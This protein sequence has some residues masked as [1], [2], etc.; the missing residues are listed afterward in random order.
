M[1]NNFFVDYHWKYYLSLEN[2]FLFTE[3]YVSFNS[4]NNSTFS[5]EYVKLLQ[6]I[7][8]EI[9]S[10]SKTICLNLDNSFAVDKNTNI[11]KWGFVLQ[12]F[13]PNIKNVKVLFHDDYNI[14]PWEKW[15]YCLNTQNKIVLSDKSSTPKWWNIYNSVKHNRTAKKDNGRYN[16][17]DANL[18]NVLTALGALYVIEKIYLN[19]INTSQNIQYS[20]SKLFRIVG[21]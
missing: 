5:N 12:K 16:F 14:I 9:D 10:V 4:N 2:N 15:E 3:N 20:D 11:K 8:S 6:V 7:C 17:Y 19:K 13:F 18:K 1:E 21:D